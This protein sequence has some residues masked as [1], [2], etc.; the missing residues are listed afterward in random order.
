MDRELKFAQTLEKVRRLAKEQEN[1][2]EKKQIEEAFAEL[3]LTQEQ[4]EL[5]YDYLEKHHIGLGT[6]PDPE[7]H[8]SGQEQDYLAEYLEAV[9]GLARPAD[10]QRKAMILSAMAGEALAR[11]SLVE[12]YLGDVADIARLY[13]G[14]GVLLEDLI[15]EGNLAL[16]MGV[17]G[18]GSL[19]D[20]EDAPGMLTRLVMDAMEA[21]I[22]EAAQNRQTDAKLERKVNRVAEKARELAKEWGRKV[23]PQE[24]AE[25]KGLSYDSIL[26][27][28]RA[29]GF[30]IEDIDDAK[31]RL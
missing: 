6:P 13:A 28:L 31:D 4:L 8:L 19:E 22:A 14:Q 26:D 10:G 3:G 30:Q 18:L 27:A 15:G 29:S 12:A 9:S 16:A 20:P 21:C 24:L 17:E 5:V 7:E 25:E 11:Q 2:I 23:T 1:C